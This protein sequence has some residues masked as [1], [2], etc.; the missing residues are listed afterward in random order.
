ME[1]LPAIILG[2]ANQKGGV[3]KSTLT[4]LVAKTLGSPTMGKKVLVVETDKQGTLTDIREGFKENGVT[5]F[6][7]DLIRSTVLDFGQHISGENLQKYDYIFMDMPG[8]IDKEGIITMLL[9]ADILFLPL[10]PSTFD[11]NSTVGFI[12]EVYSVKQRRLQ[13]ELPFEYYTI[14]NR[15]KSGTKAGRELMGSLEDN[16]INLFE[17]TITDYEAYKDHSINYSPILGSK[18]KESIEFEKFMAEFTEKVAKFQL[19]HAVNEIMNK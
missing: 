9:N 17:T 7:Y 2:F 10:S 11:I 8:T 14:I 18:K 16:K 3:G 13:L 15:V 4:H 1:K 6:P 5:T 12:E 19:K